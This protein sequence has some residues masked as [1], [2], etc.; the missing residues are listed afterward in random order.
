MIDYLTIE[1]YRYGDNPYAL[2]HLLLLACV[3]YVITELVLLIW[4]YKFF[5]DDE[6]L[7][8]NIICFKLFGTLLFTAL[9]GLCIV[10]L[11]QYK[12]FLIVASVMLI[13]AG[14]AAIGILIIWLNYKYVKWRLKKQAP[15]KEVLI[16]SGATGKKP[17][18]KYKKQ[19]NKK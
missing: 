18:E 11:E 5:K 10:L 3:A 17:I 1:F 7:L 8:G 13:I 15:I 9:L 16:K 2:L 14:I 19:V 12:L 6:A 4:G